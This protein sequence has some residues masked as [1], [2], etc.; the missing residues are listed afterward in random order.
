MWFPFKFIFSNKW[1]IIWIMFYLEGKSNINFFFNL[2]ENLI[3][4]KRKGLF[5]D[6]FLKRR[7]TSHS[8][9]HIWEMYVFYLCSLLFIV[10]E[11]FVWVWHYFEGC[12][13]TGLMGDELYTCRPY[14]VT[15]FCLSLLMSLNMPPFVFYWHILGLPL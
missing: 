14:M 3:I 1:G 12:P 15:P 7:Y 10:N 2:D 5:Y 4:S 6:F 9:Y 11:D 8:F 13:Y